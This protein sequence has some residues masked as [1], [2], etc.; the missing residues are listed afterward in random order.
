VRVQGARE[1]VA[2]CAVA[3]QG[4]VD[5][6]T[7]R[8]HVGHRIEVEAAGQVVARLVREQSRLMRLGA[9]VWTEMELKCVDALPS[10]RS[11]VEPMLV[12]RYVDPTRSRR[13]SSVL[14]LGLKWIESPSGSKP[15]SIPAVVR[16]A[17]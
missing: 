11:C 15:V 4:R 10:K 8:L 3:L 5:A 17:K 13:S 7:A 9:V 2:R 1:D 6:D 12:S 16:L 14:F